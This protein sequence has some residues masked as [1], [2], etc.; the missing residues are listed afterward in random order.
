MLKERVLAKLN[1]QLKHELASAYLYFSM[2][3]YFESISLKGFANWMKVQAQE[4]LAHSVRIFSYINDKSARVEIYELEAPKNDWGSPLAAIEDA[5]QHECYISERINECV[6][7]ALAENDHSTNTF[8][9][10]FVA[11][12]VEEE[13]AA[14]DVVQKLKLI[15]DNS[16]GL[17]LLDQELQKRN[18]ESDGGPDSILSG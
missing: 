12:Q 9:Q 17:F 16:S 3:G 15:G 14:D 7:L 2:A 4:E 11:E 1:E 10:W 5:H 8:L 13:A 6:S 18:F